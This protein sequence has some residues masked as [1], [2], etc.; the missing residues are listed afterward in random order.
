[1]TGAERCTFWRDRKHYREKYQLTQRVTMRLLRPPMIA[2]L[3]AC[4]D[5]SARRILL[6][7]G[8]P[9]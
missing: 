9:R 5:E 1:M 3:K 8:R 6:G 2:Q 4:K 7:I